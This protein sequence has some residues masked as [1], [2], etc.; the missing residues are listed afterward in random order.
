MKK[1][2]AMIAFSLF[3]LIGASNVSAA[4]TENFI[5]KVELKNNLGPSN[6]YKFTPKGQ[7]V[8]KEDA[9]I[10]IYERPHIYTFNR[11]FKNSYYGWESGNQRWIIHCFNYS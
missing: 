8:L 1:I 5:I 2:F 9:N 3:M 6:T 7:S 4:S 10:S 11:K